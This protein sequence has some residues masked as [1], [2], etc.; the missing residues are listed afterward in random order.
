MTP[1][2]LKDDSLVEL[3]LDYN[4]AQFASFAPGFAEL[5]HHRIRNQT[6][7]S[8][9][10][11][12]PETV[13]EALLRTSNG[14]SINIRS[15]TPDRPS[16]NPF[17]YGVQTTADA[18]AMIR[19]L[20][21]SGFFTIANETID[22]HDGGVSGVAASGLIEFAPDD[23]PRTVEKP[24]VARF[25]DDIGFDIL[26][27]VYGF[28]TKLTNLLGRRIEFSL[29][30]LRCGT[31]YD[32]T[33]VWEISDSAIY[34]GAPDIGIWPNRFSKFISD[35]AYGLLVADALGFSVPRTTAV[36]RNVAP[37]TFGRS[38][39]TSEWWIRTAPYVPHPGKFTTQRGWTDPF[40]LLQREDEHT[41]TIA[42]VLSQEG[43][44]GA[45]SGASAPIVG[46]D[47][48]LIEGIKGRGDEF[49]LGIKRPMELPPVIISD[50]RSVLR[51]LR[52]KLGPVRIEW[53]HDGHGVW[54]VQMHRVKKPVD[55][56]K[57]D[58]KA[59]ARWIAYDPADG[60]EHLRELLERAERHR[61]GVNVI[62]DFGVTSHIG[63]LL[64]SARV[65]VRRAY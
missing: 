33:I 52:K 28:H 38:T 34:S 37:F 35:K 13:L 27:T 41:K 22:V 5:R 26:Q 56:A 7:M 46:T 63:E 50:V 23:T 54:I 45:Y 17:Y 55:L 14:Q 48:D 42:S 65:P 29:H 62:A 11:V 36:C 44:D 49:M 2:Q 40:E 24:G 16:G 51:E 53:V 21:H 18:A 32:H 58:D 64:A 12:D 59:V 61:A 57:T 15:F 9:L 25:P 19:Q 20:S 3:A 43:I 60:L 30:P 39:G 10:D 8:T 1:R 47:E 6:D 31:R 4:I